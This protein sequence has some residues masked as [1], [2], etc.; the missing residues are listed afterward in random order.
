MKKLFVFCIS[1]MMVLSVSGISF[2]GQESGKKADNIKSGIDAV[3]KK[4]DSHLQTRIVRIEEQDGVRPEI[5]TVEPGTVV[6]WLNRFPGL[7][8][9]SF[10]DKKVTEACKH[11]VN[12]VN[13]NGQY[14][15]TDIEYGAVASLCFIEAGTFKYY[16]ERSH[17]RRDNIREEERAS[18]KFDGKIIVK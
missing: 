4:A 1:L 9:I 15:S 12:F 18:F 16:V 17:F 6:I 14:I 2:S 7:I 13:K 8:N 11:P 3:K 10:T 5:L